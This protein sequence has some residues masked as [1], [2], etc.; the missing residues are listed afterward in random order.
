[1][2]SSTGVEPLALVNRA[3]DFQ[4]FNVVPLKSNPSNAP[5]GVHSVAGMEVL[6]EYP[7]TEFA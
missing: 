2:V 4:L 6:D 7:N 5:A 3:A 1:M